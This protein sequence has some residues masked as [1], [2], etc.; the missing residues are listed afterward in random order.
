MREGN[1][2][3]ALGLPACA[4]AGS[5]STNFYVMDIPILQESTQLIFEQRVNFHLVPY[6]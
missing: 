3:G 4:W 2:F 6:A 5:R 1:G